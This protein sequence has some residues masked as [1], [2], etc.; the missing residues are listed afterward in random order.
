[1]TRAALLLL[2]V[3][4]VV[5]AAWACSGARSHVFPAQRYVAERRCLLSAASIDVVD[6]KDTG[7]GCALKCLVA[8]PE[9]DAG[10][11]VYVSTQCPPY[12]PLFDT[13]GTSTT[14]REAIGA[15]DRDDLCLPDGGS[16]HPPVDTADAAAD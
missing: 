13:T 1:M 6:G 3:A 12:P 9:E 5:M 10:R 11:A 2:A 4:S 14:C 7:G 16:T 8:P 15:A